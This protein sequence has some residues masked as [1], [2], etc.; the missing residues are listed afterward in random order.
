MDKIRQ[1]LD[2]WESSIERFKPVVAEL[3]Q[4]IRDRH[5]ERIIVAIDGKCGSGK[6]T[7]AT[8]LSNKYDCNLFHMDDFFLQSHQRVINRLNEVG[9]NVD[10]ERFQ[11]EVLKPLLLGQTVKYRTYNCMLQVIDKEYDIHP[12]KLNI[13]EGSYSQHPYFKEPYD[14][15]IF[16]DI[17]D[18]TQRE[19]IRKRNGL[20]M[21][22]LFLD[23]WIP[24]ENRYFEK[25]KI[26][27]KSMLVQWK[28]AI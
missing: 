15:C 26:K 27:E 2:I 11:E 23:K 17:D 7:L 8:Y 10:Y 21:L 13:I 3:E 9:G 22:N 1:E 24:M 28:Q 14:L 25:F 16:L 19:I 6:T 12:K 20:E 5:K 4:L 18:R